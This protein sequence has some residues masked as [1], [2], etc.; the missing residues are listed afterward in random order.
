MAEKDEQN[1]IGVKSILDGEILNSEF[2]K[3]H[4]AVF[5]VVLIVTVLYIANGYHVYHIEQQNKQLNKEIKEIRAEY[6]STEKEL[7]DKKK[8]INLIEQI[9]ERDLGLK[10]L[11]QP[12]FTISTNG[13]KR[14]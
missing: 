9:K 6:V 1:K 5:L 10:E 4:F 3:R 7:L 11:Q 2:L 8:Y 12:A 13:G 14:K